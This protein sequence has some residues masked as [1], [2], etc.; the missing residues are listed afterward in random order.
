MC[1]WK[2]HTHTKITTFVFL[3]AIEKIDRKQ[4]TLK[5]NILFEKEE[6]EGKRNG[7]DMRI[8]CCC[9]F[10]SLVQFTCRCFSTR[11][12]LLPFNSLLSFSIQ[13]F[14]DSRLSPRVLLRLWTRSGS[15][16]ETRRAREERGIFRVVYNKSWLWI[17]FGIE[18]IRRCVFAPHCNGNSKHEK[19]NCFFFFSRVFAF[20]RN[21][22]TAAGTAR[23]S[24]DKQT[25]RG[26]NENDVD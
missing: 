4:R 23:K 12:F 9:C 19:R 16:K 24:D 2:A 7:R 20:L 10:H 1:H 18:C 22:S 25:T 15:Q 21:E 3:C 14:Y 5:K 13:F 11:F 6:E 8:W 26:S 17:R